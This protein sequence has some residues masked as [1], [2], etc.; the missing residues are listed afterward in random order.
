[1]SDVHLWD[2]IFTSSPPEILKE[3]F[4]QKWKFAQP[5]VILDVDEFVFI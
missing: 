4:T 2:Q 1:M 5:H 3:Y